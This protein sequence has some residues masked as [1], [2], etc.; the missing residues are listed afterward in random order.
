MNQP[1]LSVLLVDDHEIVLQGM[2]RIV[3]LIPRVGTIV[4][5]L[6]G[7]DAIRQI[8][9]RPFDLCISDIELP[10]CSGF[11]LIERIRAVSPATRIIVYTMHE[12]LWTIR[13]LSESGAH[14]VVSKSSGVEELRRALACVIEGERYLDNRLLK[15]CRRA[16]HEGEGG[17]LLSRRETEVLQA[18]VK[19]YNTNEI[20]D[21][22]CLSDNTIETHRRNLLAK[23]D[24]HNVAELVVQAI[25]LGLVSIK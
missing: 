25:R 24:V 19:G 22:L 4:A 5:S 2:K 12:E 11:E 14:A 18:I 17:S 1:S 8:E 15:L 7:D 9:S 21:L 16:E 13:R 23:L 10:G 6:S 3:E 20:A